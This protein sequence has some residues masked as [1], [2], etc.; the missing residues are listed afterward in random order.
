MHEQ[1]HAAPEQHRAQRHDERGQGEAKRDQSVGDADRRSQ[2]DR[3]EQPYPCGDRKVVQKSSGDDARERIDRTDRQIE[4]AGDHQDADAKGDHAQRGDRLQ[5]H[6]DVAAGEIPEVGGKHEG[7]DDADDLDRD[8]DDEYASARN[9]ADALDPSHWTIHVS[10]SE[11]RRFRDSGRHQ[12]TPLAERS[13]PLNRVFVIGLVDQTQSASLHVRGVEPIA[14]IERKLMD[15]EEALGIGLLIHR[16]LY[17]AARDAIQNLLRNVEAADRHLELRLLQRRQGFD[18]GL[19][20]KSDDRLHVAV[21]NEIL[22]HLGADF[23]QISSC[24]DDLGRRA[25]LVERFL[26]AFVPQSRVSRVGEFDRRENQVS[27]F[28]MGGRRPFVCRSDSRR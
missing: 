8:E 9:L 24:P 18:H 22:H 21:A 3:R 16:R 2:R 5:H 17:V 23:R 26:H 6:R 15:G 7:A 19:L 20:A 11:S 13:R 1:D 12:P 14:D 4:L 10:P 28:Q 27:F 25:D